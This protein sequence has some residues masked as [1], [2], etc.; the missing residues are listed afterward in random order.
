M[1]NPSHREPD[2]VSRLEVPKSCSAHFC[3][4][5]GREEPAVSAKDLNHVN[6]TESER[7]PQVQ[8]LQHPF[9]FVMVVIHG[10]AA[11]SL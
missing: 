8:I 6:A 10:T 3:A 1:R 11:G 7:L 4:T 9:V 5:N 2:A